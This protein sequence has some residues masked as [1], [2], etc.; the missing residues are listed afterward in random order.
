MKGKLLTL[1][2]QATDCDYEDFQRGN[3]SAVCSQQ[4]MFVRMKLVYNAAHWSM[5]SGSRNATDFLV[6]CIIRF[7][8]KN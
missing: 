5:I 4:N 3:E 1:Y 7:L 8:T 6:K 2:F